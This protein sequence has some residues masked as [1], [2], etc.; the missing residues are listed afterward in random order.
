MR[1]AK[2]KPID[3]LFEMQTAGGWHLC[4]A[5]SEEE[6]KKYISTQT[7]TAIPI[8]VYQLIGTFTPSPPIPMVWRKLVR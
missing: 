1:K 7:G 2:Q 5:D 4:W 8:R 3:R 6:V